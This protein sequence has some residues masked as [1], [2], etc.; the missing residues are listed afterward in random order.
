LRYQ[1]LEPIDH[2]ILA[3]SSSARRSLGRPGVERADAI[4]IRIGQLARDS[5]VLE[6]GDGADVESDAQ[7]DVYQGSEPDGGR[8]S[9]G[10]VLSG[11]SHLRPPGTY[12]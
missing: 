10:G 1:P 9:A 12:R 5:V 2:P 11:L 4:S 7:H 3:R 8:S 6:D